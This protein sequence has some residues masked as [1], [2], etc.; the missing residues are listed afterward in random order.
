MSSSGLRAIPKDK[1]EKLFKIV[2][3]DKV[4]GKWKGMSRASTELG[5]SRPTIDKWLE[6]YPMGMPE[7]PHKTEPKYFEEFEQTECAKKIR[8]IYYDRAIQRL[9]REGEMVFRTCREAWK[10]RNKQDPLTF[11]LE[12]FLFFF[13]TATQAPYPPFVDP[14]T[15][16]ISFHNAVGLRRAMSLGKARDLI[17]DPRFTTRE[18]KREKGRRRFWYLEED[19]IIKVVNVLNEPDTL[20]FFYLDLLIG[21][22]GNAARAIT[23]SNIHRQ[24]QSLEIYE[25]KVSRR[26][27]KDM[28]D[29]SLNL[30]WQYIIDFDIKERLFVNTLD[31]YNRRFIQA[32]KDAGLP[33]EK[34]IT[35]HMFKHTCITQMSLHGVDI[36]VI[37]DY[38]GTDADTIMQFYRGGGRE[39]IRAQILDLPRH[40]ETWKQFVE[41]IHPFFV[42]RY[43]YIKPL[44]KRLTDLRRSNHE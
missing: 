21:G 43:N 2:R 24:A 39:K 34:T 22:R 30:I 3:F 10:A 29:F 7:K 6:Q 25:T 27:E 20:I 40:Q 28:F 19:E 9:S 23:V 12:D 11:D 42:A 41:K 38:V 13:G 44:R 8:S 35:S 36:D 16:K 4:S 33:P 17:D 5:I 18:L 14:Q 31:S 32:S 26:V 37:S 1:L 15:N